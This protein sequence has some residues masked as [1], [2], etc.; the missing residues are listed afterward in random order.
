MIDDA[1]LLAAL[2]PIQVR[3]AIGGTLPLAESVEHAEQFV[4]VIPTQAHNLV[5]LGS[6]GGLPG[7]VI[8]CRRPDL[9][10]VL[11]E[12]RRTRADL[13]RRAVAALEL[14]SR[15]TVLDEDVSALAQRQPQFFDV[16][17]ARS[18]AAPAVTIRWAAALLRR[19][20][21]LVVSEPPTDDPNRWPNSLLAPYGMIDMGREQ[22]VRCFEVG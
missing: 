7:L 16:A 5:D 13:L 17:T 21:R 1:I 9:E 15:V 2:A 18:F 3:G 14:V 4:A 22:G 12:R 10:I 6:G 11:V 8:A 20:G 19:G